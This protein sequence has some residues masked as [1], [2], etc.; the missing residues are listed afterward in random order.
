MTDDRLLAALRPVVREIVLE[1]LQERA[2]AAAAAPEGYLG[3]AAAARAAGVKQATVR[4]WIK[5]G[6]P[7]VKRPGLRGWK[8]RRSDLMAWIEGA[9]QSTEAKPLDLAAE[10]A[11]RI[12]ASV[13]EGKGAHE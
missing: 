13:R 10:R 2:P 7:A 1:V 11:R 5:L 3:S 12:A 6:L 4:E 9:L 8:I